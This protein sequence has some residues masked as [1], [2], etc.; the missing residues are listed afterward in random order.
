[1]VVAADDVLQVLGD[2]EQVVEV[3]DAAL[4][5]DIVYL[6]VQHLALVAVDGIALVVE[7][8]VVDTAVESN[9]FKL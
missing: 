2:A 5:P 8:E 6:E 1:M 9:W 7:G 4:E 3:V